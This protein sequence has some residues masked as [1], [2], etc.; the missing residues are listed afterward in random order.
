[1]LLTK[2]WRRIKHHIS[3]STGAAQGV[4]QCKE[5]PKVGDP[6]TSALSDAS[7][8]T[9]RKLQA[10]NLP[11][12]PSGSLTI[13]VRACRHFFGNGFLPFAG[14]KIAANQFCRLADDT[15]LVQR[16]EKRDNAVTGHGIDL[17]LSF[18]T[19]P[20]WDLLTSN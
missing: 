11:S 6:E 8:C 12:K 4:G 1:M 15:G 16:E 2:R 20:S 5:S 7:P 10:P 19:R 13:R 9:C 3:Y 17:D 14:L 18:A